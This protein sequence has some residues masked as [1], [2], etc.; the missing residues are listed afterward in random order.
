[1]SNEMGQEKQKVGILISNLGTPDGPTPEPVK[2]YLAQFLMDPSVVDIPFLARW[3]LVYGIILQTRPKK[4]AEAYQK[5]WTDRGSPLLFH[6]LDLAERLREQVPSHVVVEAGMRYGNPSIESAVDRLV[7]AGVSQI[8]FLP[9]YPQY[10]LAATYS[11]V[12]EFKRVLKAKQCTIAHT[13]IEDFWS[14]EGFLDAF[15]AVGKPVLASHQID[16]VLFSFH[17]IPERHVRKTDLS[18]GS[19]CLQSQTCC[20]KLVEANSKCYRAQ[21]FHTAYRLAEKLG[22]RREQYSVSF[23]SR[24]GR[25][26]WI[27]PYTDIVLDELVEKGVKR[28]AVYCPS[29]VA[30]CLETLEEI[31]MRGF[32]QFKEKGGEHLVLIP[33]LNSSSE[34]TEAVQKMVTRSL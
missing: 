12:E 7:A 22:L 17:G 10:S 9:L 2:R 13:I 26:P 6:T 8:L 16:H 30:D 33:S 28:L 34:W 11:S 20:E 25:T 15:V 21:S 24:L 23:Q 27:Q 5:I 29:F 18:G 31:Q 1:M 3:L 32:E 19:H 14:D 4:S